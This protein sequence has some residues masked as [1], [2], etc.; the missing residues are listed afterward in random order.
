MLTEAKLVHYQIQNSHSI[1]FV[2]YNPELKY[3]SR[4]IKK[5]KLECIQLLF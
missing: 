3:Q 2:I 1:Q 4:I 5:E